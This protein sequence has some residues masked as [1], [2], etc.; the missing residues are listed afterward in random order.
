MSSKPAL[1]DLNIDILCH[2]LLI[3]HDVSKHSL[4]SMI[5]A[6]RTLYDITLPIFHRSCV[7]DYSPDLQRD[8]IARMESWLEN[9]S[10]ILSFTRH[11]TVKGIPPYWRLRRDESIQAPDTRK[12]TSL[13]QVL[14]RLSH[15]ASFTFAYSEQMPIVLLD[16]L[17][18]HHRSSRLHIR[19]WT[20]ISPDTPFGDPAEDALANSPCLRSLHGHFITGTGPVADFR[21]S[22]FDRIAKLSPNLEAISRTSRSAGGCV[23]YVRPM[24]QMYA[25]NLESKKFEVDAPIRKCIK[26][27]QMD[28]IHGKALKELSSYTQ[29]D[30]LISLTNIRPSL[31]FLCLA[32]TD[33]AYHLPA[34]KQ[35]DVRLLTMSRGFDQ[36]EEMVDAFCIFLASS[37][38]LESL[39]IVLKTSQSWEP[40]LSVILVHHAR[41]I[42]TLSLHQ[43]E[44]SKGDSMRSCLTLD[45][46]ADIRGSCP[47]LTNLALDIDR[48]L[49]GKSECAY[50]TVLRQF[51]NLCELTIHM[52]LG[53]AFFAFPSKEQQEGDRRTKLASY[54][55]ADENFAMEVWKE[56][57]KRAGTEFAGLRELV[58]CLGEQHRQIGN[59]YPAPWVIDEQSRRQWVRVRRSER[60]DRPREV[61][62]NIRGGRPRTRLRV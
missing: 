52:D 17:H 22:A 11:I 27:L 53:I 23:M 32:G 38:P 42:R 26:S 50:Y 37:G 4:L 3:V 56:V 61:D 58:L 21:F 16:A 31:D 54:P 60:D 45:Q 62:I 18:H 48:T 12:W 10:K 24:D 51:T 8:T 20:R 5:C 2:I 47:Q 49:E 44:S 39:S 1:D 15:L 57:S 28:H 29:L 30:Q 36:I 35:L 25:Q 40:I 59:G 6:N 33:P 7:M 9:D 55:E 34:L 19:N 43:V 13:V 41:S 46:L 14:S